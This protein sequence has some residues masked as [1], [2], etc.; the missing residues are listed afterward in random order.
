[1]TTQP[2]A[3]RLLYLDALRA[4]SAALLVIFHTGLIFTPFFNYLLH[5]TERSLD[6]SLFSVILIHV[7]Q[8]PLLF[9]LAGVTV[10]FSL[11]KRTMRDY[12]RERLTRLLIPFLFGLVA[13]IPPQVYFDLVSRGYYSGTLLEFY[14]YYFTHLQHFTWHH[15]W[16][17]LYLLVISLLAIPTLIWLRSERSAAFRTHLADHA[18]GYRVLFI[19][20]LPLMF[21]ETL[22]RAR[23]PGM[24]YNLYTDWANVALFLILF[25]YGY[26]IASEPRIMQALYQPYKLALAIA[27][28]ITTALLL[29]IRTLG[30][31]PQFTYSDPRY[32]L[33]TPLIALNTWCW[34]VG[35]IGLAHTLIRQPS[36]LWEIATQRF[37]PFY[38]LHQTVLIVVGFYVLQ[39]DIPVL[40]RFSLIVVLTFGITIVAVEILIRVP[41]LSFLLGS[42]SPKKQKDRFNNLP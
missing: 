11:R 7:W 21:S 20:A 27:A 2:T 23:F 28:L 15:L 33:L 9:F 12:L 40:A 5:N 26:L 22:L 13:L 16:F 3:P 32:Y 10:Y 8:M 34:I 39:L 25:I 41:I 42:K 4:I 31:Q 24:Y 29:I 38:L 30:H 18:T 19:G 1:M 14:P 35:L 37:Y 36:R 6:L 17:I